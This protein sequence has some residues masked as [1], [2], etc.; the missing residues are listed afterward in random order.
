MSDSCIV[1]ESVVRPRQEAVQC[2]GCERWQHRTCNTDISRAQYRRMVKE[3][4]MVAFKCIECSAPDET[5]SFTSPRAESTRLSLPVDQT[6]FHLSVCPDVDMPENIQENS[7]TDE[8]IGDDLSTTEAIVTYK[9]VDNG[10]ERGKR[11]LVS[12]DGHTFTMKRQNKGSTEWRCSIRNKTTLCPVIIKERAGTYNANTEH[13]HAAKPGILTAVK[14][15]A[16]INEEFLATAIPEV[17]LQKDIHTKD[18]RHLLFATEKQIELLGKAKTWYIDGTFRIVNKPF[19]QLLSIHSF[20]KS[21]ES[22]KQVPLAF[23]L[24]SGKSKRDYKKVFKAIMDMTP[25]APAVQ[26]FV[27]DFEAGI[28]Q[29]L[30]SVFDNPSIHDCAFHWGQAVWR[31]IQE[32][33]LQT[34]YSQKDAVYKFFRKVIEGWHNRINQKARKGNLQFYLLISLLYKEAAQLP[35]QMKMVSEGKLRR[36]QKKQSRTTQSKLFQLWNLYTSQEIS[37]NQLLKRCGGIYGPN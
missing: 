33:G 25:S 7:L 30:R 2:D 37:T 9:V 31:K 8:S 14:I 6:T 11:K 18:G 5:T 35:T 1:C 21:G 23:V 19:Y 27:A 26:A 12:S 22:I 3:L 24:M 20:L 29:A 4:T 13:S 17:F 10:T 15:Q 28:W 34:A 16:E 32:N 36:H